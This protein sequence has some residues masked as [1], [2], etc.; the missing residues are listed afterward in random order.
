VNQAL[1]A[2]AVNAFEELAFQFPMP[3]LE[4]PPPG[5]RTAAIVDFDGHRAGKLVLAVSDE[6]LPIIAANML[7]AYGDAS[8]EPTREEQLDA[9]KEMA[10]VIC[11]N[12]LPSV[13]GP[14]AL[15]RLHAP[16][17]ASDEGTGEPAAQADVQMLE[18]CA[19]VRLFLV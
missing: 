12:V 7:G 16:R 10:N 9:L 8:G 1:H 15:F 13:D 2:A 3:E 19:T 17:V 14:R 6:L 5:R 4:P 18:G 11:G